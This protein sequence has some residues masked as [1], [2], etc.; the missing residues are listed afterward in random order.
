MTLYRKFGII[1][2]LREVVGGRPFAV[3]LRRTSR[4]SAVSSSFVNQAEEGTEMHSAPT[5]PLETPL[6][7]A[8]AGGEAVAGEPPLPGARP[9]RTGP[10]AGRKRKDGPAQRALPVRN[11]GVRQGIQQ[12]AAR[13]TLGGGQ[14]HQGQAAVPESHLAQR[15]VIFS[16]PHILLSHLSIP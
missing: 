6:P 12:S 9:Q 13:A 15:Q 5:P 11:Q 2:L 16:N 14:A 1:N 10:A 7:S 4:P 8:P 3:R